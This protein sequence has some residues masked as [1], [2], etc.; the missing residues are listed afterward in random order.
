MK[1]LLSKEVI[2][3]FPL[4]RVTNL[5]LQLFQVEG[6]KKR[7]IQNQRDPF[8]EI[9]KKKVGQ[10]FFLWRKNIFCNKEKN[11]TNFSEENFFFK[12]SKKKFLKLFSK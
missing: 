10:E 1:S 9:R 7:F 3:S 8:E 4:F 2:F 11:Q 5:P 6:S 12:I